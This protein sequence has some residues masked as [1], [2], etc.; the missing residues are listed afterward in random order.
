MLQSLCGLHLSLLQGLLLW[1]LLAPLHPPACQSPLQGVLAPQCAHPQACLPSH[2]PKQRSPQRTPTHLPTIV[3]Q[4]LPLILEVWNWKLLPH[5]I[6][7]PLLQTSLP[8]AT[9]HRPTWGHRLHQ[10]SL[11]CLGPSVTATQHCVGSVGQDSSKHTWQGTLI[12]TTGRHP[13]K[14]PVLGGTTASTS[15]P[16]LGGATVHRATVPSGGFQT[17]SS[18][19][20]SSGAWVLASTP[21]V[22]AS[23]VCT[24]K[25]DRTTRPPITSAVSAGPSTNTAAGL[26]PSPPV[27]SRSPPGRHP[28]SFPFLQGAPLWL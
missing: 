5:P 19:A 15:S 26:A 1:L 21:S 4:G 23:A 22:P 13:Q 3:F 18:Q 28:T 8:W 9:P 16:I 20:I 17:K 12:P 10:A 7:Q 27:T 14:L 11:Y 2:L 25:T 24:G 6:P